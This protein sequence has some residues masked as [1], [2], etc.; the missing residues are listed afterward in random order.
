MCK[1]KKY[2]L[3]QTNKNTDFLNIGLKLLQWYDLNARDLPWREIKTPYHIWISEI[4]LQQT[5][6]EQGLNHYVQFVE[7]FPNANTLANA[8][9]DEVLLY[10]K[11]LG[12]YSRAINLHK[13]AKQIV[14][15]FE[16]VFPESYQNILKLSGVGKYT[17][18]AISS[19]CFNEKI[20]AID[21]NF[22]RVLSRIFA[23]DF[24]I[25][26]SNAHSYFYELAL[27]IMPQNRPGDFN[28][29]VM[30]LGSGVCKPKNPECGS[31]PVNDTCVAFHTGRVAAFPV[32][33]KKVKT[34]D[35]SLLY[36]FIHHKNQFLIKQRG[37]DFIWKKL[38]DF[39]EKIEADLN[40]Y[41]K[42]EK[43]IS[44]K[45]THKNLLIKIVSI[46]VETEEIFQKI[47]KDHKFIITDYSES[48]LK[49]FPKPLENYITQYFISDSVLEKTKPRSGD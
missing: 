19:I 24:D 38:Y 12:Y 41:T 45:L 46:T 15:D 5:R 20:P 26:K 14:H 7:R 10:W 43:T 28:Q 36:Y 31:C 18:A 16:G 4:V 9:I 13:A 30:D 11:G 25:S 23:D 48:Q 35:L 39:P 37:E 2:F 3:K 34:E 42:N 29:A 1:Y 17:A 21:G 40:Q 27:L 8:H 47:A 22:Y 49:S 44:H 33:T 6:V 32:K